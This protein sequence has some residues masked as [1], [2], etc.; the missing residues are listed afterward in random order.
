MM[1][2]LSESVAFG[3]L[4]LKSSTFEIRQVCNQHNTFEIRQ[5]CDEHPTQ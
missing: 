2:T 1:M 5:V 4:V 3:Y